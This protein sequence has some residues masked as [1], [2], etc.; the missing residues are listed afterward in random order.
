[1]WNGPAVLPPAA[2]TVTR[3]RVNSGPPDCEEEAVTP[4]EDDATAPELDPV[5]EPL[6]PVLEDSPE[7]PWDMP[8]ESDVAP[9]ELLWAGPEVW[10]EEASL[11]PLEAG[12]EEEGLEEDG[13]DEDALEDDTATPLEAPL[14]LPE[15]DT[16]LSE[17]GPDIDPE[18]GSALA[19]THT[20]S[21]QRKPLLQ[22]F[23]STQP[24]RHVPSAHFQPLAHCASAEH[25]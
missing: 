11:M 7:V 5:P 6:M 15:V 2:E 12:L 16:L 23:V 22:L 13:W 25:A 17:E 3:S 20:P 19:G 9:P 24:R 4:D 1:M 10:L 21:A 18:D 14:L 8:L